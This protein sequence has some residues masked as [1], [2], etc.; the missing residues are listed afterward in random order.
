MRKQTE[1]Y[2]VMALKALKRAARKAL[3]RACQDNL[4]VPI[5]RNG[6]IE[7]INLEINTEQSA[8]TDRHS[9][10]LHSGRRA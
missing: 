8:P 1:D 9:A 6:K 7:Y 10:V 4:R 5:W 2:T 3:E